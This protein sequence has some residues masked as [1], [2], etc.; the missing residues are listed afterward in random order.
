MVFAQQVTFGKH[1]LEGHPGVKPP[2]SQITVIQ[3]HLSCSCLLVQHQTNKIRHVFFYTL[4]TESLACGENVFKGLNKTLSKLCFASPYWYQYDERSC[5]A[6]YSNNDAV[7][8]P[9][10]LQY[11]N[12]PTY[13]KTSNHCHSE[14]NSSSPS[15]STHL[16]FPAAVLQCNAL[17]A[18]APWFLLQENQI[19]TSFIVENEYRS[20]CTFTIQNILLKNSMHNCPLRSSP[21]CI[22]LKPSPLSSHHFAGWRTQPPT[23]PLSTH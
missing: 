16:S 13:S 18:W 17:S 14:N 9:H 10:H 2:A 19:T 4:N 1:F 7:V 20:P 3:L 6:A 23:S 5:F 12:N 15:H 11:H 8:L 22:P 21:P